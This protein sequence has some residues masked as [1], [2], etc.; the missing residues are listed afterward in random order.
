MG[1]KSF[2]LREQS[3]GEEMT[4]KF[5][6][7]TLSKLKSGKTFQHAPENLSDSS[8]ESE[9]SAENFQTIESKLKMLVNST[10][11]FSSPFSSSRASS[12]S[13]SRS[14]AISKEHSP[15]RNQEMAPK[16]KESLTAPKR[17]NSVTKKRSTPSKGS[18]FQPKRN[19]GDVRFQDS[20]DRSPKTPTFHSYADPAYP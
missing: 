18:P 20:K 1:L 13:H 16:R 8:E 11:R 10:R 15:E 6:S 9:S 3:M 7:K 17:K 5:D 19:L 4:M 14:P 2:Y 12:R